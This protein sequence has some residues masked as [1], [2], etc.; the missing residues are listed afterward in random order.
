MGKMLMEA[1]TLDESDRSKQWPKQR[2]EGR[3]ELL[4]ELLVSLHLIKKEDLLLAL[5]RQVG[6]L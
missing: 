1:G 3:E 6:Q 2:L 4:G 5:R